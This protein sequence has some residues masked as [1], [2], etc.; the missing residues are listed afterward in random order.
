MRAGGIDRR[1]D[2]AVHF[3]AMAEQLRFEDIPEAAVSA[4]KAV[5]LDTIG[6]AIA[7]WRAPGI[8][9]THDQVAEWGGREESTVWVYGTWVPA[10]NAALVNGMMCHALEFDDLHDQ[11]HLHAFG[12]VLP[13]ALAAAE[14][15]GGVDGREFLTAL[16]LG[17]DV[18]S[19]LGLAVQ[20]EK[21]WHYTITFGVFGSAVACG[22]ILGMDRSGLLNAL[23]ISYSRA[24]GT[25]QSLIE[26]RLVKRMHPGLAAQ[27]GV[28]AAHL[29][30]RGI[31]GPW[32]V[33]EGQ[34]GYY[35]VYENGIYDRARAL[36]GLG[37]RFEVASLRLKPYPSCGCTHP[38]LDATLDLVRSEG[39]VP[40][41]VDEV[42]VVGSKLTYDLVGAPFEV[43]NNPQADAQFSIPYTVAT[44]IR[45]GRLLLEDM[46]ESAI[47]DP[48]T[49][50]LAGKVRVI[51]DPEIDER[52]AVPVTVRVRTTDGRLLESHAL[53]TRGHPG[54]P[55]R[56]EEL[57]AKFRACLAYS[58]RPEFQ[59]RAGQL[60]ATVLALEELTDVRD[61]AALMAGSDSP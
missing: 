2:L 25:E 5:L 13:S 49:H 32:R 36:D 23:G 28:T 46:E 7:G 24:A 3:A 16:V 42:T 30:Q 29:A 21:G 40:E 35:P 20:V 33:F 59:D 18:M 55:L 56:P 41:V 48:V 60:V 50:A 58:R 11:A 61:L 14:R 45:R 39:L 26:A 8:A 31:T 10:P 57:E 37:E 12:P 53:D 27:A 34:L 38:A 52:S 43:R 6:D 4:A 54:N 44:A 1:E 47:R 19:R 51:V 15:A 9:A 22:R 17:V